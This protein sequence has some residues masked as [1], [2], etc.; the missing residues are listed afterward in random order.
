MARS[1]KRTYRAA[2]S[3]NASRAA[4][5]PPRVRSS[6]SSSPQPS[7]QHQ[8]QRGTLLHRPP[9]HQPH[10]TRRP[11]SNRE[12]AADARDERS[13]PT[14]PRLHRCRFRSH[15]AMLPRGPPQVAARSAVWAS[16]E[17]WCTSGS[18]Q[19]P[20]GSTCSRCSR[21]VLAGLD[22]LRD[23]R[24]PRWMRAQTTPGAPFGNDPG[25]TAPIADA[26]HTVP[27]PV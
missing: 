14:P 2:S 24:C 1:S 11:T 18:R 8:H 12:P 15:P 17:P 23:L 25:N 22:G 9:I 6:S 7:G 16:S 27:P 10:T 19:T 5:C 21:P 13:H 26:A 4:A 3:R 20:S